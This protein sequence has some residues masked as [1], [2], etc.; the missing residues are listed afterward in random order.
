MSIALPEQKRSNNFLSSRDRELIFLCWRNDI[1]T[2]RRDLFHKTMLKC[3]QSSPKM[4]EVIAC[5]YYCYRDLTKWPKLN[6]ICQ[7]IFNFF[8]KLI[9]EYET[10]EDKM[11]EAC[12]Q[13]GEMHANYAQYGLKPHFMDLFQQQ[14]LGI[15]ARFEMDDKIETCIAFTHLITFVVDVMIQAYSRKTSIIRATKR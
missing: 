2:S 6:R 15:I 4:N 13:L 11:Y 14:L 10:D 1:A 12:E 8:D 5:G 9:N 7:A 3:I